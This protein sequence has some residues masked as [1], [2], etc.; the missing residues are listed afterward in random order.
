VPSQRAA[1]WLELQQDLSD[2]SWWDSSEAR[3]F[4]QTAEAVL[5]LHQVN[6]RRT[7]YYAGQSWIENHDPKN[8]DARARRLFVLR[9]TQSSAKQDIDALLAAIGTPATGQSGWG[10]AARYRASPLDTALVLDALRA[11]GATFNA[12]PA[13]AYLKA[14]QLTG[15][16][17]Q[18]WPSA[19]GT[20]A[21]SY[22][23]A[24]VVQALAAHKTADPSLATPLANAIA[25][26]RTKVGTTSPP[27]LRAAAALAYLRVDPA[28]A[29]ASALLGSLTVL[30][31]PDGGFD[32]GIHATALIV[33]AFAA[34]EGADG[35]AAQLR[36]DMPDGALRQAINAAL[37]RGAMDQLNRGELGQLTSLDISNRGVSNLNGLQH[38]TSLTSLNAANNTIT[39]LSPIAALNLSSC[40]FAGNPV[41]ACSLANLTG[42]ASLRKGQVGAFA[43]T[44]IG[45]WP[46]QM[47]VTCK[48]DNVAQGAPVLLVGGVAKC[49]LAFA[50]VGKRTASMQYLQASPVTLSVGVT[51]YDPAALVPII[52]LLLE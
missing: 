20:A 52:D 39:D 37:G 17:N 50:A 9:A 29:D 5:A 40:S 33:Q 51:V 13:I 46:A 43:A 44:A 36:V 45:Y 7:A 3:T 38:A 22:T 30:Q 10:L 27:H 4:L 31:R 1:Q 2:G 12:A 49:N 19:G 6:R 23:T 21:D 8:L 47:T 28:S 26:L 18:G 11:S 35:V 24:R 48:A 16:G 25:T 42:P 32:A 14:S 15:T 41:A 34:A